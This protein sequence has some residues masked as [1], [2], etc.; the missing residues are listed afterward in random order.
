M[1]AQL[2][3]VLVVLHLRICSHQHWDVTFVQFYARDRFVYLDRIL[4]SDLH[5]V[6]FY[7]RETRMHGD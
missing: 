5:F 2:L 1:L 4:L 3:L 6:A 7:H